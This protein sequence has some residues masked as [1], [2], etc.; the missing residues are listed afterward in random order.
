MATVFMKWLETRPEVYD[1]GIR[2][3]TLG[4]LAKLQE[5]LVSRFVSP[6]MTILEIGCGTGALTRSAAEAGANITAIDRAPAMLAIA[7]D[8][9]TE[10]DLVER[11]SLKLMDASLIG[12][13]FD[14]ESFDLVISSLAFSEM[15]A[16]SRSFVLAQIDGLLKPG[17]KI[18]IIDETIPDGPLKRIAYGLLRFPLRLLTWLLT[19][20][21][22]HPLKAFPDELK[23]SGYSSECVESLMGGSLQLWI[24]EPLHE[25]EGG[26][27]AGLE[28]E[29]LTHRRTMRTALLDIWSLFFRII[30]PYPK[31]TPGLYKIG[32]PDESSPILVTGNYELTVR[33]LVRAI[34]G[35]L[36]AW[37]LVTD[38]NGI[39]VWCAAGGGFFTAE[40]I[41]DAVRTSGVDRFVKHRALILPQLCA[42]GVDGWRIREE[43]GWGVHWG[44]VYAMD[45][46]AYLEAGRK[47]T[48]AVRWVN[49]P[50]NDRLEM[51]S[52]TLGFYGLLILI[53]VA[54]FWRDGFWAVMM[55]LVGLGLFYAIMMPWLPG[56]D[57]LE[58]S[59]PLTIIALLGM[60]IYTALLDPVPPADVFN[61]VLGITALSVFTAAELQGMSP[62]MRGEQANWIPEA[63]V[64]S[65]LLASYF[66]FPILVGW[67]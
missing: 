29:P 59:I 15:T 13:R 39:N 45:I 47:K 52:V 48:D 24:A 22:T 26:V 61:R 1:R 57:G 19:R 54:I 2:L 65:V 67:R 41:I 25:E 63:L 44:P 32:Q 37:I 8:R 40:R 55:A 12:D 66:L 62:L 43:T 28:I 27:D 38:S 46:P 14:P 42:N 4:R 31:F 51:L 58:K 21:T 53:P 20:T 11:V 9:L 6:S 64:G 33:R 34:E 49:F 16:L 7:K 3:L 18:A 10:T 36:D 50:L 60:L 5:E 30:P 23:R 17:G 35:S 56:R